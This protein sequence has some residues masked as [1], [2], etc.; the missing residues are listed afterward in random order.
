[1]NCKK[2]K[3]FKKEWKN[4]LCFKWANSQY[5]HRCRGSKASIFLKVNKGLGFFLNTFLN[6][7]LS[8]EFNFLLLAL[9][10]I[11][12]CLFFK[13]MLSGYLNHRPRICQIVQLPLRFR[14]NWEKSGLCLHHNIQFKA[15]FF[16]SFFFT[17]EKIY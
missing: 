10:R 17:W 8:D 2:G 11:I 13:Q 9:K 1:M 12:V 6:R 14:S 5:Q 15:S 16:L 4:I 7:E 3:K